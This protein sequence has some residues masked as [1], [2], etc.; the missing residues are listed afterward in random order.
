MWFGLCVIIVC[1]LLC[2]TCLCSKFTTYYRGRSAQ[3]VDIHIYQYSINMLRELI[4]KFSTI[5]R[6]SSFYQT[7]FKN[8]HPE[9]FHIFSSRK[10]INLSKIGWDI[11]R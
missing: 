2:D 4:A 8:I 9:I 3:I 1:T 10:M 11:E 6:M 7:N 5:G